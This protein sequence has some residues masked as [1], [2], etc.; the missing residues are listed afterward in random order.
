[1]D[2][3]LIKIVGHQLKINYLFKGSIKMEEQKKCIYSTK[4]NY[5]FI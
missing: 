5:G 2:F 4:M 3:H 1:M